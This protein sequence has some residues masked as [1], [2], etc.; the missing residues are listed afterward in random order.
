MLTSRFNDLW[1]SLT[2]TFHRYHTTDRTA[3]RVIEL[4][5]VRMDLDDLRSDIAV[6]REL[7]RMRA[8]PRDTH[9]VGRASVN[10]IDGDADAIRLAAFQQFPQQ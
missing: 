9:R 3:E 5:Q 6:E 2:S 10:R 7:I 1:G 4:A 8:G